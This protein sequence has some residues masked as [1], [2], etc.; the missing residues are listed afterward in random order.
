MQEE[1]KQGFK[2]K[3]PASSLISAKTNAV[4]EAPVRIEGNLALSGFVGAYTYVRIGASIG[5]QTA[6]IGRYCSIAPGVRI[7]DG[8]HPLDWLSTHPFQRGEAFWFADEPQAAKGLKFPSKKKNIVGNDVWLSAGAMIMPGV[9]IG[10]G[11]VVAAGCVVTKDVPPYAIV[12]GVPG[13]IIDYRFSPDIIAQLLDAQW[14]RYTASSLAGMP[15]D[16]IK[17]TLAEIERRKKSGKLREIDADL[18]RV[19]KKSAEVI[20]D[21]SERGRILDNFAENCALT[22]IDNSG[23]AAR[24]EPEAGFKRNVK[25]VTSRLFR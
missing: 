1:D 8:H 10:D 2:L 22:K 19:T 23:D 16:N 13:R 6:S 21:P 11:A 25:R 7:G 24:A 3:L 17:R 4:V 18:Y 20:T 9:K 5:G 15:F 12:A 14:W